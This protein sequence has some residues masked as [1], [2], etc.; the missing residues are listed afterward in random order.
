[1]YMYI[2]EGFIAKMSEFWCSDATFIKKKLRAQRAVKFLAFCAN[3]LQ[4][5]IIFTTVNYQTFRGLLFSELCNWSFWVQFLVRFEKSWQ[6]DLFL[7]MKSYVHAHNLHITGGGGSKFLADAYFTYVHV[8][9]LGVG[10]L[11][12]RPTLM[13]TK[14]HV[15]H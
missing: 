6:L 7:S 9:N 5:K 1:M 4:P 8:H 14:K 13:Y 2:T 15:F 3:F 11:N 10:G 12:F